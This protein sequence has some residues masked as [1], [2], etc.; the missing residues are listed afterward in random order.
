MASIHQGTITLTNAGVAVALSPT[1]IGCRQL[2]VQCNQNFSL[3]GALVTTS[4]GIICSAV[5][6]GGAAVNAPHTPC[7]GTTGAAALINL[8][9][10]FCVSATPGAVVTFI[11]IA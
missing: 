4:T 3:G 10:V 7:L 2:F 9:E 6:A 1:R 11:Y 8:A 5:N